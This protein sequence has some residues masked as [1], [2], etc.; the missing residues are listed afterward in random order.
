MNE[1]TLGLQVAN[2]FKE[3]L[4]ISDMESCGDRWGVGTWESFGHRTR[5]IFHMH[6]LNPVCLDF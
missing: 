5:S 4:R 2:I 6:V 1:R 3:V